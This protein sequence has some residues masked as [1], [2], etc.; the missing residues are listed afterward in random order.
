MYSDPHNSLFC[1]IDSLLVFVGFPTSAGMRFTS[2]LN[3]PV[4]VRCCR[5]CRAQSNSLCL[6]LKLRTKGLPLFVIVIGSG[7][8]EQD[9]ILTKHNASGRTGAH[10]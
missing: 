5:P 7:F 2:C 4:S 6:V 1:H 10:C 3:Q 8:A 9:C